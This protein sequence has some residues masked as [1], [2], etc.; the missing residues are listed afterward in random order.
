MYTRGAYR[1]GVV[2][3]HLQVPHV[4]VYEASGAFNLGGDVVIGGVGDE[5]SQTEIHTE[6]GSERGDVVT[7]VHH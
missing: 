6:S 4:G 5:D 7:N 2:S 3:K 1:R